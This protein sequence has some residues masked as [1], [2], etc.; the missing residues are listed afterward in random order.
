MMA[1][2]NKQKKGLLAILPTLF[3]LFFTFY[4]GYVWCVDTPTYVNMTVDRE[5]IY[6]LFLLFFRTIFKDQD[7]YLMVA[8]LFQGLL[9]AYAIYS[10][11]NYLSESFNLKLYEVLLIESI[12]LGVS[13]LC[14]F[15]AKRSSMYSNSIL[16]ESLTYPLFVLFFRYVFQYLLENSNKSLYISSVLSFLLISTRKQMYLSLFL[17]IVVFIY[18]VF[19]T[20][21]IKKIINLLIICFFV[22]G[23]NKVLDYSYNYLVRG[24]K[25]THT[26]SSRFLATV[27]FYC[28]TKED[29]EFIKTEETKTIFL[30][31]HNECSKKGLLKQE[32]RQDWYKTAMHFCD[33][34]DLIQL[35]NMWPMEKEYALKLHDVSDNEA[36]I[37]V[38]SYSNEI[39]SSLIPVI[40]P[41]LLHT[42]ACN[43]LL[44]LMTT[45]SAIRETFKYYTYFICLAYLALMIYYLIK[46][47]D[48]DITKLSVLTFISVV[49]N[50]GIVSMLIFPQ[51]RYT[52]YN[53]GLFYTSGYMM[54]KSIIED[55]FKNN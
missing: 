31:V 54:L 5:P 15:A 49:M 37:I 35:H 2:N 14:R 51:T 10:L 23:S 27:V 47:R 40:W 29:A 21:K 26:S 20:K 46:K 34:Y 25:S 24:L 28:S 52:I 38:D 9:M 22:I 13:L 32:E 17:L 48:S 19:K 16:S 12:F 30:A 1:M 33:N 7:L 53:M 3:F 11:T 4:D 42:F 18:Q 50:V 39:I 41:S 43:F 55:R 6:P 36:E 8:V 45:V 44:G